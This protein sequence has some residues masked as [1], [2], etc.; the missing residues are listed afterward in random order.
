MKPENDTK[1]KI[2]G[3]QIGLMLLLHCILIPEMS[4]NLKLTKCVTPSF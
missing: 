1:Y 4:Q 2:N 3:Y